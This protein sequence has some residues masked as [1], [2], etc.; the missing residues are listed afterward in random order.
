MDCHLNHSVSMV[1]GAGFEP[2]TFRVVVL[3]TPEKQ[4]EGEV[5][6]QRGRMSKLP[7]NRAPPY[8]AKV[9]RRSWRLPL[10]LSRL[11]A[12][13]TGGARLESKLFAQGL[14][15]L[16][17]KFQD[18]DFQNKKKHSLPNGKLCFFGC[19]SRIWTNNLRVMSPTSYRIALSRDIC[20]NRGCQIIIHNLT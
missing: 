20:A 18:F 5:E 13:A 6:R 3:T 7:T 1:A 2:T 12:S 11:S 17:G 4:T 16:R 9:S 14:I 10:P 15:T 19:G 8:G